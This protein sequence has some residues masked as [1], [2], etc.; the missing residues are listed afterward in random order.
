V[1]KLKHATASNVLLKLDPQH[2]IS[3]KGVEPTFQP[4]STAP[5]SL[6]GVSSLI[7]MDMDNA[8]AATGTPEG[9]KSL[10]KT[11]EKMDV[12]PPSPRQVL[13]RA[14]ILRFTFTPEG[15]EDVSVVSSPRLLTAS[16][17]SAS[18][19]IAGGDLGFA[20]DITPTVNADSTFS[21]EGQLRLKDP[22]GKAT[23]L[24]AFSRRLTANRSLVVAGATTSKDPEIA[25]V[26]AKGLIP[27]KLAQHSALYLQV[28]AVP[29]G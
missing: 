13:I 26:V 24:G 1:F 25:A 27:E 2:T 9:L 11:L 28:T 21:L 8:I 29:G 18:I 10:S 14:R 20:V 15:L 7:L 5:T 17:Q 23:G 19:E 22:G 4:S 16:G 3:G 6:K 12:A